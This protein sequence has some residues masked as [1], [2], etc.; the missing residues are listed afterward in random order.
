MDSTS[1]GIYVSAYGAPAR[2]VS[3][4]I[5]TL[6]PSL[7]FSERFSLE[8][9]P[10]NIHFNSFFSQTWTTPVLMLSPTFAPGAPTAMKRPESEIATEFPHASFALRYGGINLI[11]AAGESVK[12]KIHAAPPP[13]VFGAP[14]TIV[15]SVMAIE[16]PKWSSDCC[17]GELNILFSVA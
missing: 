7:E 15:S 4:P 3:S 14:T 8:N 17:D 10:T 9:V 5:A 1:I 6:L 2:S 13:V 12:S 16:A 11:G